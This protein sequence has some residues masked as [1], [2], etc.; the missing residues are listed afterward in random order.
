[1]TYLTEGHVLPFSEIDCDRVRRLVQ[2]RLTAKNPLDTA[3]LYGRALG[4]VL[5]HELYHILASTTR[6]ARSG[7]AKPLLNPRELTEERLDFE[8][9]E[10][11]MIRA[12]FGR[13][14][15]LTS[16]REHLLAQKASASAA[17]PRKTPKPSL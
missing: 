15:L 2:P 11:E 6:H 13:S 4:R 12:R 17:K 7:L 5:G 10:I 3:R 14:T 1:M 9:R 8:H 16:Q